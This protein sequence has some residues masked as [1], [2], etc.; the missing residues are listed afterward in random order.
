MRKLLVLMLVLAMAAVSFALI[1]PCEAHSDCESCTEAEGC[2]WCN[3]DGSCHEGGEA[4]PHDSACSG[5]DWITDSSYCGMIGNACYYYTSCESCT[6]DS[7][8]GWCRSS[9]TCMIGGVAGPSTGSCDDWVKAYEHCAA[10]PTPT[11][12]PTATP[13]PTN[14]PQPAFNCWQQ[15][16]TCGPCTRDSR[17]G[18]CQ[19]TQSCHNGAYYGPDDGACSGNYWIFNEAGCDSCRSYLHCGACANDPKCGWCSNDHSCHAGGDYGAADGTCSG[20]DWSYHPAQCTDCNYYTSCQACVSDPSC[21]WCE[22]TGTCHSGTTYSPYDGAC[23]G[24]NWAWTQTSCYTCNRYT[25]CEQC[26]ND[27]NCGWCLNTK[28]CLGGGPNGSHDGYCGGTAWAWTV[29]QCY[30]ATPTPVPTSTPV[31]T[32][33]PVPTN[34]PEPTATPVPTNTPVPTATPAPTPTP[35]PQQGGLCGS[36]LILLLLAPLGLVA[37]VKH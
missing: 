32:A 25:T 27:Q 35:V 36:G 13:V 31:S 5:K 11:P 33:T 19:N 15:Y 10:P 9:S 29:P 26:I 2:G 14:T 18:W 3:N 22:N 6:D 30:P 4:G 8:C 17:C 12:V 21:G 1:E 16:S 28:S 34:T 23:S 7:G 20:T 24:E 37:V